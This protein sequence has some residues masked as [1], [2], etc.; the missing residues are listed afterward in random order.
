MKKL[1][2]RL[3]AVYFTPTILNRIKWKSDPP[4]LPPEIKDEAARRPKHAVLPCSTF[5]L[6]EGVG[7][8]D[9]PSVLAKCNPGQNNME[10]ATPHPRNQSQM[11]HPRLERWPFFSSTTFI[12]CSTKSYLLGKL[13]DHFYQR[14]HLF[15]L[16]L[17]LFALPLCS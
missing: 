15:L 12:Q 3:F 8:L 16:A 11:R 5:F 14:K 17:L 9:L 7:D 4:S 6:G 1:L 10:K 2:K 13:M